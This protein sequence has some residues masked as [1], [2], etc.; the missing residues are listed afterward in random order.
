MDDLFGQMMERLDLCDERVVQMRKASVQ[1]AENKAA[2]RMAVREAILRE[3]AKGTPAT[4][5]GDVVRGRQ[6]IASLCVARDC[7][8]SNAKAFQEEININKLRVR[9]L[10]DQLSREWS[11][12]REDGF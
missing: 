7:A 6:D 12:A 11:V 3:R 5:T 9:V 2:Y 1:Y 8:E 10:N 4:I